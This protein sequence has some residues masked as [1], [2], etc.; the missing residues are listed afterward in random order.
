MKIHRFQNIVKID[1]KKYEVEFVVREA[2]DGKLFY[3][4]LESHLSS[5]IPKNIVG[6]GAI[7]AGSKNEE[8]MELNIK[9][10]PIK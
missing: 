5:A 6:G 8:E 9:L 7:Y 2:N 3:E 4:L 10:T 1:N